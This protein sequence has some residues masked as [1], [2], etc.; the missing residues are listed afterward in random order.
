MYAMIGGRVVQAAVSEETAKYQISWQ[1]EHAN[2]HA[3][4]IQVQVFD[5]DGY[6]QYRK[7][8]PWLGPRRGE[9]EG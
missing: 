8:R 7:V 5:E 1:E 9:W 3:Q 6:S 2:A 4:T